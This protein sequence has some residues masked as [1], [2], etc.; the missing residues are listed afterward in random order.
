MIAEVTQTEQGYMAT[1]DRKLTHGPE[2]VW[3]MLTDNQKIHQW[4]S[5]LQLEKPGEG[6]YLSF[7]T[8]HGNYKELAIT[9]F[10]EKKRLGF[11][12]GQ[13]HVLFELIPEGEET[14]LK[15]VEKILVFTDHTPKDVAGW[16]VCL[17][18]LEALLDKKGIE[19]TLEWEHWFPEYKRLFENMHTS[20]E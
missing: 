16:H 6:G 7:D 20:F 1:F 10:E 12:W 2:Q 8:G 3:R 19:R 14:R 5:G 17:D 11:E 4:F 18:V 13:D 15:L 9:D